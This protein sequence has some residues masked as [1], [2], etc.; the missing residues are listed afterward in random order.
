MNYPN[1]RLV[2][3]ENVFKGNVVY[4]INKIRKEK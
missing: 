1:T 2:I 3:Y 4:V